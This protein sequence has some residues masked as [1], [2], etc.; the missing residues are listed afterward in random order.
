MIQ[1]QTQETTAD[2]A[3]V[4][5]GNNDDREYETFLADF[6]RRFLETIGDGPL[7]TTD[8]VGLWDAYLGAF[9]PAERQFHNCNACRH[10]IERFGGL[11]A[12]SET[13]RTY[14][15]LW[16]SAS[17]PEPY[18]ASFAALFR[19]VT[20]AKVTGV[21]MS[22]VR[23]LGTPDTGNWRHLS[24]CLPVTLARKKS[25]LQTDHQAMAEKREDHATVL[26]ALTEFP[27]GVVD[28][29][30]TLLKSDALY[31]SEKVLGQAEWLRNLH[32]AFGTARGVGRTNV[33][34][35]AV[36]QAPAGFCHPRSSMIGTLL[37]DIAAGLD[38][39]DVSRK[40]AAK[41]HPLQYQRPQAAPSAGNVA[42]AEKI[43]AELGAAGSLS[44]RYARLD[45]IEKLWSPAVPVEPTGE[46]VF[47]HLKPKG[48]E[49]AAPMSVPAQAITWEK[50]A[51]TVLP[52]ARAL[53]VLVPGVGN[54][55]ALV[56][57]ENPDAPPILQWDTA[58][59]RNPVS[60]YL[61]SGG[62]AASRWGLTSGSWAKV[63]AVC[64]QPSMWGDGNLEHQG[65]G[66]LFVLG[67]A[68]DSG[69][70]SC[71]NALFP[72][73]LKA[74]LR[75]IRSTIESYSRSAKLG[76]VES[77]SA[78]GLKVG[79]GDGGATVRVTLAN[80]VRQEWRIDRWD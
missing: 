6:S 13:G 49:L 41:M 2:D 8:A 14:S 40:F 51:R 43:I 74:E 27:V 63:T 52:E 66:A 37:E 79:K 36:A 53:D 19:L 35:R 61:Y 32:T 46:G 62:S 4:K 68:R 72:E 76:G 5:R 59:K 17:I 78:N 20:R 24:A 12:I 55:A 9:E 11:V 64:L 16:A 80:G 57:A 60:W 42:Q 21:F 65:V 23:I 50:F 77:A 7:F 56:T 67:G 54:F 31:R 70:S 69:A 33:V 1:M 30:L 22:S 48:S 45:E 38:F 47:G 44:R 34:W 25:A 58:E 15:V 39:G 71:G 26:R 73:T 3:R 29:A 10:F 75:G 18:A 28:Q